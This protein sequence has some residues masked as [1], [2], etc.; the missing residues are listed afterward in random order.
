MLLSV[1]FAASAQT[2]DEQ[3][4]LCKANL[5]VYAAEAPPGEAEIADDLIEAAKHNTEELALVRGFKTGFGAVIDVM[6][7]VL[8][9]ELFPETIGFPEVDEDCEVVQRG[10]PFVVFWLILGGAFFTFRLSLINLR[11]FGHG[12][13]VVTNKYLR[14]EDVGQ[15]TPFQSLAAAVSGTV[16]LG[17][18]A[19]VA[20][21]VTMGGPGAIFWMMVA[22]F[23]GMSTKFAEVTLGHK[24]RRVDENGAVSGG[25]FYYLRDGLKELGMAK[26]GKYLA[27][28][29]AFLCLC[30]AFGGGNMFQ[31]NQM[32]ASLTHTFSL[33]DMDWVISLV[34]AVA[35]GIVLIGGVSR[36]ASVAE[37]IV[38][39]MALIYLSAA[40]V[41][42][43][44]N[45]DKVPAAL[46]LIMDLAFSMESAAGGIF[47]AMIMG[48]RRAAFS[49]EAGVGSA[50]IVM[51][52][53]KCN[54]PVQVGSVAILEPFIDTMVIC[55]MT[56]LVITVTGVYQDGTADGVILTSQSFATVIDWFPVVL[57]IAV[58]LFA[59]STMLTWSYYGE[60]AWNYL[61]GSGKIRLYHVLFCAAVFFGGAM[62][63]AANEGFNLIVNFSDL[64]L[65]AMSVPNLIGMYL[66]SGVLSK[67]VKEYRAR[68]KAGK[69]KLN[70]MKD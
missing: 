20:V 70:N 50:P 53:T 32:V 51:A 29:F 35:V 8:F 22:G 43:I 11:M 23:L 31:A 4:Q 24:Y 17:N 49:N 36:I 57:S 19:G 18:I 25:A 46:A 44:V 54:E 27:V 69:V 40:M 67:E 9:Y 6:D 16:G 61:F 37:A 10:F 5:I 52:A 55:L 63:D 60:R 41:V 38:P 12:L 3:V 33:T 42:L 48:F 26:L 7:T 1:P 15:V 39:L 62:Q 2:L 68:L 45:A 47:G 34:M 64:A 30:G 66:L 56:G 14:K 58:S 65:L 59:F 28:L 13:A 21:A